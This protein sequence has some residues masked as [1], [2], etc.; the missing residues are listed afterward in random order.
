MTL[1]NRQRQALSDLRHLLRSF[2]DEK[3]DVVDFLPEYR[4]LFAP[5]DPPDLVSKGLSPQELVELET[6]IEIAGGWFGESED[7]HVPRRSDWR[8]GVDTGAYS[9]IDVSAYRLRIRELLEQQG[10]K[11]G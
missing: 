10:L 11:L 1:I 3:L 6:L 2:L 8:Y 4:K 5:F 9:W 7:I